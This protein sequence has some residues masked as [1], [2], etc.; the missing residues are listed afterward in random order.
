MNASLFPWRSLKTRVTH[1]TLTIFLLSLGSL[2]LYAS[3]MLHKDMQRISGEQQFSTASFIASEINHELADRLAALETVAREISPA[4]L[5]NPVALQAFLEQRPVFQRM[6]NAGLFVTGPD[7]TAISSVPNLARIG[8]NYAERDYIAAALKERLSKIGQPVIGKLV[9]APVFALAAPIRDPQCK[10]IGAM[11]GATELDKPNFLD[12]IAENRYGKTGSYLL[13]ARQNRLVVTASDKNRIMEVL[14]DRDINAS[15]SGFMKG[16]EGS[17]VAVNSRGVEVL[18]SAKGVP[19][20]DWI[21]VTSIPTDEAFDPIRDMNRRVLQTALLLAL[22]VG[23]LTWWMLRHELAPMLATVKTLATLSQ[24]HQ[25][26]Q[27]L[28]VTRRDEIG[29]LIGSFNHLLADLG[30]RGEALKSSSG[31][32]WNFRTHYSTSRSC[33][34]KI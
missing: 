4:L 34:S 12:N 7:G 26:P 2:A 22:L 17:V 5:A 9:N 14:P 27:P 3:R 10:V 28:P 23:A 18:A 6:F 25:H 8:V 1:F 24:S 21:V 32:C 19:V 13:V 20:A 16:Y 11:A 29:E 30:Q 15:R 33:L 31:S